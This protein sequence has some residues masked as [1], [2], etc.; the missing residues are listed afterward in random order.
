MLFVTFELI[1]FF[2]YFTFGRTVVWFKKW[3]F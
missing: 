1:V 3:L 2:L